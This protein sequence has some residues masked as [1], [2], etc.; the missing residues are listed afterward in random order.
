MY[1][2]VM[3]DILMI[4]GSDTN[5]DFMLAEPVNLGA[6]INTSFDEGLPSISSDGLTLY[7]SSS[8]PGGSGEN[9]IWAAQR[10]STRDEWGA[11][12]NLGTSVNSSDMDLWPSVSADT[13]TLYF[14]SLRPGGYGSGDIWQT[15]RPTVND[16][17]GP[18]EN[19]GVFVNSSTDEGGP[20]IS[21]DGLELYFSSDRSGDYDLY[22]SR[23]GRASDAW[24]EPA[25]LSALNTVHGDAAP[26]LSADGLTLFFESTRSG[27][28][29]G[30]DF[31]MTIREAK[32][33][34]WSP[35][36]N[37]GQPVNTPYDEIA[38]CI[39]FD[40]RT[41]YFCDY[42]WSNPHPGGI[43][44]VDIWQASIL[45]VV[46]F[47]G[48]DKVDSRDTSILVD[49]WLQDEPLCDIGPTPFG[50]GI[51]DEHDLLVLA[52]YLEPGYRCVAHWRLDEIEGTAAY[53]CVG[54]NDGY[55]FGDAT[56]QLEA[57]RFDGAL[58]LDGV[59]DY[60]TTD[61]VLDPAAAPFRVQVWVKGGAPGQTIV[62]QSP[63]D[64]LGSIWLGADPADGTLMTELMLPQPV[65]VSEAVVTDGQWHEV[66]LEWDGRRRHLYVD[67]EEVAVDDTDM[68]QVHCD[69]W[70]NIGAAGPAESETFWLGLIDDVRIES[71]T[72]KP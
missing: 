45:P 59:D 33:A 46:D 1:G 64:N 18:A 5:A 44:G 27:G 39:S 53:D 31:Y 15:V 71:R 60:F 32:D 35:P 70:L 72:P 11:A 47:N 68:A 52:E 19:L 23:R 66:T 65:L 21:T 4:A 40:G 57:G 24:G 22:V 26:S 3:A 50:D 42:P 10:T 34:D 56:W 63:G 17:W 61:F 13:L 28:F 55:V 29:G 43:G 12:V 67:A 58:E 16:P 62:A 49:H 14:Y 48:D 25:N 36:I 7:F 30:W 54:E 9:D 37:I 41:L 2:L 69:G 51:V 6:P 20:W 8:R 38:P